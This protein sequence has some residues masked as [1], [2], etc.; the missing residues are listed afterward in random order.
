MTRL[1]LVGISRTTHRVG[2]ARLLPSGR[3]RLLPSLSFGSAGASPSQRDAHR[4]KN[5][6]QAISCPL[7]L[8]L[9]A[10]CALAPATAA[11]QRPAPA[12]TIPPDGTEAFRFLLSHAGITPLTEREATDR[13]QSRNFGDTIVIF[14]GHENVR[15][16]GWL[17][18]SDL[19]AHAVGHGGAVLIA[20]DTRF[21]LGRDFPSVDTETA[22]VSGTR[23]GNLN[24]QV[25]YAG[26]EQCP[27]AVPVTP[28]WPNPG[29]EWAL[30]AGLKR[31]AT[32]VPSYLSVPNR[33]GPLHSTLARLPAGSRELPLGDFAAAVDVDLNPLAVGGAGTGAKPY[34][35][36]VV[37]D[38]SVFINQMLIA[39]VPGEP[40]TDNLV[41]ASRVVAF[42]SE[43]PEG[44]PR[45]RC[46]FVQNGQV[47]GSFDDLQTMLR[48]QL[49]PLPL[50]NLDKMQEKLVDVGDQ[51]ADR[52][53]ER[54]GP[55]RLL[56][57]D[58]PDR[59]RRILRTLMLGLCVVAAVWAVAFA[60][61]RVWGARQPVAALA[62]PP[63]GRPA[64]SPG[65]PPAPGVFDRRQ[66]E[67][68]RRNNLAEPVRAAVRELF[69]AAAAPPDAG[70]KLP[71]V[72]VSPAVARPD[73]LRQALGDLW[74]LGF[75]RPRVVTV[76]QWEALEPLFRR[77]QQA[78]AAGKWR[79]VRD[80]SGNGSAV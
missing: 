46:L 59:Q 55:S 67:L 61:R 73:T 42:L 63:G 16:N 71:P 69:A 79:F 24:P 13:F 19:A 17:R 40:P 72:E 74:K 70:P 50:P 15:V 32:N 37:A 26:N 11:A 5:F 78:H 68:L 33:S 39:A 31:V 18:P 60:G 80:S 52:F 49:P 25:C 56:M 57:G 64:A 6:A 77:V 45:T 51:L 23:V 76:P 54:G 29:P 8:L 21:D 44:P 41:F 9:V 36:L 48:P 14:L 65:D 58:D 28:R 38:P 1:P 34:R 2:R 53:Q 35:C 12:A 62:P 22:Q 4:R 7:R 10:A 30:F 20:A 27:F 3:A 75:A 66:R 47:V 43:R